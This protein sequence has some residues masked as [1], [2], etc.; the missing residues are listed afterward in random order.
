[1]S[2]ENAGFWHSYSE[3][4]AFC[5]NSLLGTVKQT[6]TVGLDPA[7]WEAFPTFGSDEV[8]QAVEACHAFALRAAAQPETD[9]ATQASVDYTRLFIGPPKPAAAPWETFY[10]GEGVSVG[11]GQAT[12]EM[13]ELLRAA[14]LE[15]HNHN[16]Q[17]EDH[18]GIELLLLSVYA[19]R[20]AAD[21]M[22]AADVAAYV[23]GHPGAWAPKLLEAVRAES[24]E[25]YVA[26]ILALACALLRV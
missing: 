19:Q 3:A 11:F 6:S 7:F 15:V 21:E 14:G 20:V 8:A 22:Q 23:D 16:N 25:G 9:W 24:P 17:Y 2:Q 26:A 1:M 12:F 10:R 18:I 13:R 4:V 5:G